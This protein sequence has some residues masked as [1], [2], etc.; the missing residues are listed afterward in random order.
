MRGDHDGYQKIGRNNNSIIHIYHGCAVDTENYGNVRKQSG[1]KDKITLADLGD[2]WKE[3][4][5]Y[6]GKRS[7]RWADAFMFDPKDNGTRLTGDSWF[8][9]ECS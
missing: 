4:D 6:Y 1:T 7:I 9:I 3:Y 5:V 2:N 8:K